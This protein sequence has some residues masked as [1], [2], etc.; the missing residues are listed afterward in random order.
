MS[1]IPARK[2]AAAQEVAVIEARSI[3]QT[4]QER[5]FA[6]FY[7]RAVTPAVA[8]AAHFIGRDAAEDVVQSAAIRMWERWDALM[9]EQRSLRYLMTAVR[10]DVVRELHRR[11]AY[12]E[13]TEELEALPEFP[14]VIVASEATAE[15][16]QL[17]WLREMLARMPVRRKEVWLLIREFNF[18]YDEAAEALGISVRT[19]DNHMQNARAYFEKGLEAAGVRLTSGTFRKLLPAAPAASAA[20]ARGVEES[21]DD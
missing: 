16:D 6:D 10:H 8:Y 1:L 7:E 2:S 9:P 5:A 12:V 21:N 13:L 18:T 19:V 17:R 3:A 11:Q 4:P 20:S 14:R 15:E